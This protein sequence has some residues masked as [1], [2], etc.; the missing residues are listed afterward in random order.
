MALDADT[1]AAGSTNAGV[2]RYLPGD[3][4]IPTMR[5][6]PFRVLIRQSYVIR[7][8][9]SAKNTLLKSTGKFGGLQTSPR[10]G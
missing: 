9:F 3:V 4:T 7:A 2:T 8:G 1:E 5:L 10:I 6:V